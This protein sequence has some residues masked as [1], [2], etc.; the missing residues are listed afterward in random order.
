MVVQRIIFDIISKNVSNSER[1]GSKYETLQIQKTQVSQ[2]NPQLSGYF[3]KADDGVEV[4]GTASGPR[5][6]S[7]KHTASSSP[8]ILG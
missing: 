4:V 5:T 7:T 6:W 1:E 2:S 8:Q 3:T